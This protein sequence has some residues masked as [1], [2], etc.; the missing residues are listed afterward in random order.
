MLDLTP[1]RPVSMLP[2][3]RRD[4]SIVAAD[5]VDDELLGDRARAALGRDADALESLTV[6]ARTP[7][8]RL[9][10]PARTRLGTGPGQDN[11]LLR[12]VLRPLDRTLTDAEANIVRD[13]VYAAVH[14]GPHHEWAALPER[15]HSSTS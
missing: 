10:E 12:M 2:A 14:E 6:L 13:R 7:H 4:L 8:E 9:P 15:Q 5:D 1:W 11:V 3:V